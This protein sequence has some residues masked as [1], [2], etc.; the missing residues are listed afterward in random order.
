LY[1]ST[2]KDNAKSRELMLN[3]TNDLIDYVG[4]IVNARALEFNKKNGL[5]PLPDKY[6]STE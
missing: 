2:L 1:L 3:A 6:K 4:D 5:Q